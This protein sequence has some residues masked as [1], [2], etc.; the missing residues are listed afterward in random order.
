VFE[1][2]EEK[3]ASRGVRGRGSGSDESVIAA[4]DGDEGHGSGCGWRNVGHP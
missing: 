3:K 1:S 4:K 2:W